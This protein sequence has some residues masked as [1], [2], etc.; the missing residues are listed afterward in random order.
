M[1]DS[2]ERPQVRLDQNDLRLPL[3][4]LAQH[5]RVALGSEELEDRGFELGFGEFHGHILRASRGEAYRRRKGKE[6]S[7][8]QGVKLELLL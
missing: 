1:P 7:A 2:Q 8:M 6:F 3:Y 5:M 4:R